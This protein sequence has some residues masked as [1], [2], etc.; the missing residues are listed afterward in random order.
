MQ[1]E[2]DILQNVIILQEITIE[3]LIKWAKLKNDKHITLKFLYR[4]PH[5]VLK[6]LFFT[7]AKT[8]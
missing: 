5:S 3:L 2:A 4:P 7:A 6:I 1:L 8:S